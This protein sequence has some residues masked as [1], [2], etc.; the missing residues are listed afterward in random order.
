MLST[1]LR[2]LLA[3]SIIAFAQL[4]SNATIYSALCEKEACEIDVSVRGIDGPS[5]FI[6]TEYISEWTQGKLQGYSSAKGIAG[7]F[8]GATAGLVGG[9]I[10][11]GPVGALGGLVAGAIEGRKAGKEFEGFFT[12]VGFNEKGEKIAHSFYFVNKKTAR[13]LRIEL[14][15]VTGLAAGEKRSLEE[16]EEAFATK[17]A[18]KEKIARRRLPQQLGAKPSESSSR[19]AN[20]EQC[21]E[22]YLAS[23]PAM[24]VWASSNKELAE[25]Q[26]IQSGF[27]PCEPKGK[28]RIRTP[29]TD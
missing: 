1:R 17:D 11:L 9:A 23:N 8:G 10:L 28:A 2:N 12:V 29:S 3:L 25:K 14:P 22:D 16:I 21:W 7:S 20:R 13:R 18:R 6:P 4:P 26:R 15:I 27:Q 19:S 24:A 5:G